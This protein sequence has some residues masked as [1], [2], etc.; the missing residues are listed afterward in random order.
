[1]YNIRY[2]ST[3]SKGNC[4]LV[5]TDDVKFLIDLGLPLSQFKKAIKKFSSITSIDFILITHE[6][7]DHISGA[8]QV[9]DK[10]KIPCYLSHGTYENSDLQE[11]NKYLV[12]IVE[13]SK[14]YTIEG[15]GILPFTVDHD[16]REPLGFLIKN[17]VGEKLLFVA[18]CGNFDFEVEA[19][20]Y[21]VELNYMD[22]MM[23]KL[24]ETEKEFLYKRVKGNYGHIELEK[25]IS[26]AKEHI[27]KEYIFHHMSRANINHMEMTKRL[28]EEKI[29]YK[30]AK[31]GESFKF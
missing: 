19:D 15:L 23:E 4:C 8:K 13:P 30:L 2:L 22:S 10:Y 21:A 24:L 17:T 14:K 25:A 28:Y 1:M 20:I 3:G 11:V 12:N 9:I 6:H 16:A 5:E 26:F 29:N 31:N 27:D 18:D 7:G